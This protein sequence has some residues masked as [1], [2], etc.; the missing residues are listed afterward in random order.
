MNQAKQLTNS[1]LTVLTSQQSKK[2]L[3]PR[4]RTGCLYFCSKV[5]MLADKQLNRVI[6]YVKLKNGAHHCELK[7]LSMRLYFCS[8]W[9]GFQAFPFGCQQFPWMFDRFWRQFPGWIREW[10]RRAHD[11]FLVARPSVTKSFDWTIGDV[12]IRYSSISLLRNALWLGNLSWFGVCL[13]FN[14]RSAVI[15]IQGGVT[16]FDLQR[17]FAIIKW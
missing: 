6:L 14:V 9:R 2:S 16:L 1:N 3:K 5:F 13:D 12:L 17:Q 11:I 4:D 15:R 8:S 7:C 10:W